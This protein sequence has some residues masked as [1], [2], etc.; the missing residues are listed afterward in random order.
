PKGQFGQDARQV[1]SLL[2]QNTAT[3]VFYLSLNGFDTHAQQAQTHANLLQQFSEGIAALIRDLKAADLFDK[4]LIMAF[5][6]FGRSLAENAS[7]G[8]DHGAA[9]PVFV[10][11]QGL[12][13]KGLYNAA[14]DLSDLDVKGG[15]TTRIDFR[16]LYADILENWL[17]VE[18]FSVL[19]R[20]FPK[21][22]LV[23]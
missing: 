13:V 1:A 12:K 20:T 19:G 23:G 17:D 14:P 2:K 16:S 18:A 21:L 8:T 15:L 9:N 4:V 5:S 10:F 3:S 11:G 7:F 22:H 6:E